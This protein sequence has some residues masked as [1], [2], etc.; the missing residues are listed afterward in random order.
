VVQL[1]RKNIGLC[2]AILVKIGSSRIL[3]LG[4]HELKYAAVQRNTN[5]DDAVQYGDDEYDEED[6]DG[7]D[8][9]D[10]DDDDG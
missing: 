3:S 10:D 8:D 6:D 7:D 4:V 1:V 9:G 5:T 2:M